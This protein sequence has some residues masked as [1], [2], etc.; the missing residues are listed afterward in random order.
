MIAPLN[1]PSAS[2][3]RCH[4]VSGTITTDEMN[5]LPGEGTGDNPQ[6][7]MRDPVEWRVAVFGRLGTKVIKTTFIKQHQ[8]EEA[9]FLKKQL[10]HLY[11]EAKALA[12]I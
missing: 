5:V 3:D 12:F 7:L 8:Q 9:A 2:I 6:A 4:S 11:W 1:N 10:S